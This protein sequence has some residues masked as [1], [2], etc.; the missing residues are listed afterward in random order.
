MCLI[1]CFKL[2]SCE[3]VLCRISGLKLQK[4]LKLL[5]HEPL[6]IFLNHPVVIWM[7][8]DLPKTSFAT[9]RYIFRFR[10]WSLNVLNNWLCAS[11][12]QMIFKVCVFIQGDSKR[13]LKVHVSITSTFCGVGDLKFCTG[14]LQNYTNWYIRWERAKRHQSI[15][16]L[17]IAFLVHFKKQPKF[18]I[19]FWQKTDFFEWK[20]QN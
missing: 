16:K 5:I 3:D 6:T 15:F 7:Y 9:P 20:S 8:S 10:N 17:L 19:K 1:W 12:N 2:Y 14:Q 4:I 13:L 11:C 18:D